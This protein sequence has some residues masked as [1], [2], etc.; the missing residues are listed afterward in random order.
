MP[1]V[2]SYIE[3]LSAL[4]VIPANLANL[5][6]LLQLREDLAQLQT[7]IART[8]ER[9]VARRVTDVSAREAAVVA[10]EAALTTREQAVTVREQAMQ[11]AADL[12]IR[13]S[14]EVRALVARQQEDLVRAMG[15][16][17]VRD[18]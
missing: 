9:R 18:R 8:E 2:E 15:E 6:R 11:E 3:R 16:A 5:L 17:Q 7:D 1:L 13:H 12:S 10:R 14:D 4:G